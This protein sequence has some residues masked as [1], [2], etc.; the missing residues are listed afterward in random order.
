MQTSET[1]ALERASAADA[2]GIAELYLASRADAL[3]FLRRV[4]GDDEVR[5]WI[6]TDLL[7]RGTTWLAR[8]D[9]RILGF[10]TLDGD[11]LDQL[12]LAPGQYRRGVGS[13]LLVMAKELSSQRLVLFT[14][15]RNLRA[16]AFYEARGFRVVDMNDGSRNEEGEPDIRYEWRPEQA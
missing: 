15:Q 6:A 9:G 3:P 7:A 12:Y 11:D 5:R 4:H 14:F 2:A 8:E 10:M 16:R 13:R 1:I